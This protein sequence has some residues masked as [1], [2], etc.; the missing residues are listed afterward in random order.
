VEDGKGEDGEHLCLVMDVLGGNVKSLINKDKDQNKGP[1]PLALAKRILLHTLRGLAYIHGRGIVHTDLKLDNIMFDRG[2]LTTEDLIEWTT[3]DP[4]RHNPPEHSA[5][6]IVQSAVSQ[7]L[8]LPSFSDAMN[9]TYLIGD[10]GSGKQVELISY[11]LNSSGRLS[12]SPS[13]EKPC[14]GR[15]HPESSPRA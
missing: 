5:D 15:Y 2:P 4:P 7:P 1:V 11:I 8:P 12:F 13:I 10:L 9:R 3:A 14:C 6:F